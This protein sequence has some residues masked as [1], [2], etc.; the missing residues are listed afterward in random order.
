MSPRQFWLWIDRLVPGL[1]FGTMAADPFDPLELDHVV[2]AAPAQRRRRDSTAEDLDLQ[3][4][5]ATAATVAVVHGRLHPANDEMERTFSKKPWL[6][7]PG[8][9]G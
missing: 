8:A 4:F 3:P 2:V 6:P 9:F 5:A 1:L 7:A